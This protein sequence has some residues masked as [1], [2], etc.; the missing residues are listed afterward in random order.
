MCSSDLMIRRPPRSTLFPY[1]TLFR[2]PRGRFLFLGWLCVAW[3]GAYDD[4]SVWGRVALFTPFGAAT[5]LF[6]ALAGARTSVRGDSVQVVS[7]TSRAR[8]Q[9][10]ER[11]AA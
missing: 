7:T 5:G 11:P 2:S 4:D 8:R 3:V 1:T 9:P 6:V 10:G